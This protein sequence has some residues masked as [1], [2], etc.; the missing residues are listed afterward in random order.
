MTTE[1][2]PAEKSENTRFWN[3]RI[4]WYRKTI[5]SDIDSLRFWWRHRLLGGNKDI[6]R[7]SIRRAAKAIRRWERRLVRATYRLDRL[8]NPYDTK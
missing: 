6:C 8:P 1:M 4:D 7:A 5:K 3:E 2:T